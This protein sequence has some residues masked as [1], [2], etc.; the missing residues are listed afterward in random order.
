M[1]TSRLDHSNVPYWGRGF[2]IV[3][4]NIMVMGH[5]PARSLHSLKP[6]VT[7]KPIQ[8]KLNL[9]SGTSQPIIYLLCVAPGV[10]IYV[11]NLISFIYLD[12]IK[13][14]DENDRLHVCLDIFYCSLFKV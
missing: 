9:T 8:N 4:V 12:L 10:L 5:F 3:C 7:S 2:Y 11:V 6:S 14:C 1:Y 13:K